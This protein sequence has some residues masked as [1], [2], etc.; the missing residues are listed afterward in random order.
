MA[1][2]I[3]A[4]SVRSA[5]VSVVIPCYRCKATIRRALD[6]VFA[7]TWRPVEVLLVEDASPDDTLTFLEL[8][9]KEYPDNWVK[10]YALEKNSGP[11]TA[12]NLAWELASQPYVAFLDS[13]DSWHPQ[14]IEIQYGW[15]LSNVHAVLT[16]QVCDTLGADSTQH[17]D[18]SNS[19]VIFTEVAFQSLLRSNKFSTPSVILKKNV[20]FRFSTEMRFCE[21]YLLWCEL[22]GTGSQGYSFNAALTFCHKPIYGSAGLSSNLW[23]MEKG[24]LQVYALLHK[25]GLISQSRA[26]VLKGW[27][28]T[29][30]I[31]R[32]LKIKLGINIG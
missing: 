15:M 2:E 28:L 23:E 10:V 5:N 19:V 14:K 18:Y 32:L 30:Y 13:D 8:L 4:L 27:S 11:A 24:E 31:R 12:R 26:F 7:Q 22:L 21:D 1:N 29:R 17:Q 25:R 9:L 3:G 20:S 6:S 16:G